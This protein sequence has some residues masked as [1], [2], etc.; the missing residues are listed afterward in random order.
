MN[1]NIVENILT[2]F[3]RIPDINTQASMPDNKGL[4]SKKPRSNMGNVSEEYRP[5]MSAI[6]YKKDIEKARMEILESRKNG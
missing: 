1:L 5:L 2:T 3:D 6:K 4:L